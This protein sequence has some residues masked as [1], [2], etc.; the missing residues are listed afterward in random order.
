MRS[1]ILTCQRSFLKF[2]QNFSIVP[3]STVL[4]NQRLHVPVIGIFWVCIH[5][6]PSIP[7]YFE[8]YYEY[9][10]SKPLLLSIW[11]AWPAMRKHWPKTTFYQLLSFFVIVLAFFWIHL[12][13]YGNAVQAALLLL[14]FPLFS[15]WPGRPTEQLLCYVTWYFYAKSW[16]IWQNIEDFWRFLTEI[17]HEMVK[18]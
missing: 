10:L 18:E 12:L 17:W 13:L 5:E 4:Y 11:I 9:P 2:S 7:T 14:P 15:A 8:E 6:L 3:Y 1:L 16:L